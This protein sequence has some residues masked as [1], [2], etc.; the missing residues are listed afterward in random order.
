[1]SHIETCRR[2]VRRNQH[3]FVIHQW[4]AIVSCQ[5]ALL[6]T[7]RHHA[8]DCAASLQRSMHCRAVYALRPSRDKRATGSGGEPANIFGVGNQFVIHMS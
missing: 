7:V 3:Q 5:R 1:M 4:L 2:I 6:Q 8:S